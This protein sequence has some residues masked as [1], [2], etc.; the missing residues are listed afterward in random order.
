MKLHK[1]YIAFVSQSVIY[2]FHLLAILNTLYVYKINSK[3]HIYLYFIY[4]FNILL[5]Y[6]YN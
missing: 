1:F 6:K 5:L 4:I 3:D 2:G